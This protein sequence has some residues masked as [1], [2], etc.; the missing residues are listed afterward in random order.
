MDP[1]AKLEAQQLLA[2]EVF[3]EVVSAIH[4]PAQHHAIYATTHEKREESRLKVIAV[5]ELV[6]HIRRIA[7][8]LK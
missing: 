2:M 5:D 6:Q 4:G 3:K 8:E 7:G 1:K